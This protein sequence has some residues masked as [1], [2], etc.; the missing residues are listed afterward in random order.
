VIAAG[1]SGQPTRAQ[2]AARLK[3]DGPV[4]NVDSTPV[5]AF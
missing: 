5:C 3:T 2:V 1:L 4:G